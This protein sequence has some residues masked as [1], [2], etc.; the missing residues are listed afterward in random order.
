MNLTRT[1]FNNMQHYSTPRQRPLQ[2]GRHPFSPLSTQP[3]PPKQPDSNAA[4]DDSNLITLIERSFDN[5]RYQECI[6]LCGIALDAA[7]GNEWLDENWLSWIYYTRAKANFERCEYDAAV[8]DC[9]EGVQSSNMDFFVNGGAFMLPTLH[10]LEGDCF[11]KLEKWRDADNAFQVAR[12]VAENLR[13]RSETVE[14]GLQ[15]ETE[16]RMVLLRKDADAIRIKQKAAAIE[17]YK[18]RNSRRV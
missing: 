1:P 13:R 15:A 17:I 11:L 16:K 14:D 18:N 5:K 7:R 9:K 10:A 12:E 2:Q 8:S 4:K 3:H 6:C